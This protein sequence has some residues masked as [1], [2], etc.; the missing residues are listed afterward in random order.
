MTAYCN[1]LDIELNHIAIEVGIVIIP[2]YWWE[3]G[4]ERSDI[5]SKIKQSLSGSVWIWTQVWEL[6]N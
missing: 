3:W 5:L 1:I 2:I 4:T 6:R